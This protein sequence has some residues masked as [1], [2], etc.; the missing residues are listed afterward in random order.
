MN[1][2]SS[3]PETSVDGPTLF[4]RR[5][6]RA[7]AHTVGLART[8]F[9]RWL[10]H[11]LGLTPACRT[12]LVLAVNEALANAAEHAYAAAPGSGSMDVDAR[13]DAACD[14][15]SVSVEDHGQWR[16]TRADTPPRTRGRGLRLMRALADD[17]TI[18]TTAEGTCVN[19]T[20]R[21]VHLPT[22]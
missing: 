3:D 20:W 6:L 5:R 12:D 4:R 17:T 13:Y 9:A 19:M 15:L 22:T 8:E 2:T 14:T 10:Q 1:A 18:N 11:R 21:Q 16:A 7:D